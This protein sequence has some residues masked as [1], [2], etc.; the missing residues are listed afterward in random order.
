M[1]YQCERC[2]SKEEYPDK[3][4]LHQVKPDMHDEMYVCQ[5]CFN[6]YCSMNDKYMDELNAWVKCRELVT[7]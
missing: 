5:E 3:Y 6:E 7:A 4:W 2:D 1:S